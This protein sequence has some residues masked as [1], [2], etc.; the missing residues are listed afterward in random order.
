MTANATSQK[1]LD[2]ATKDDTK[3]STSRLSD[4]GMSIQLCMR[5][6]VAGGKVTAP[7][8]KFKIASCCINVNERR[9]TAE[10]RP[11]PSHRI[12]DHGFKPV[13]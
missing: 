9:R 2:D 11:L 1:K 3:V 4:N 10:L 13:T 8:H 7:W 12:L 5:Q 6:R